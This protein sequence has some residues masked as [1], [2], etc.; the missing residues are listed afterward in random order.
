MATKWGQAKTHMPIN[1]LLVTLSQDRHLAEAACA[2]V[3]SRGEVVMGEGKGRWQPLAAELGSVAEAH[4]FH[5]WL[6]SLPGIERVDVV[7]VGIDP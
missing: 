2:Q 6:E 7:Y 4:D 1:G 5:E 3:A